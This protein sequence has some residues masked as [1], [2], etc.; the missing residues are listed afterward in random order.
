MPCGA[1]ASLA[2]GCTSTRRHREGD[3]LRDS[4]RRGRVRGLRIRGC[5]R[6]LQSSRRARRGSR[7]AICF[8]ARSSSSVLGAVTTQVDCIDSIGC[9]ENALAIYEQLGLT[10]EAVRCHA[11]LAVV[12]N[13]V[14]PP[15]LGS[16]DVRWISDPARAGDHLRH[17]EALVAKGEDTSK[18]RRALLWYRSEFVREA[19][20]RRRPRCRAARDGDCG[21]LAAKRSLGRGC[22]RACMESHVK[23]PAGGSVGAR[24]RWLGR[25]RTATMMTAAPSWRPPP[26]IAFCF[27]IFT[28]QGSDA[29]GAAQAWQAGHRPVAVSSRNDRAA[30]EQQHC[31]SRRS[32]RRAA[33]FAPRGPAILSREPAGPRRAV[34]GSGGAVR[35]RDRRVAKCRQPPGSVELQLDARNPSACP[36]RGAASFVGCPERPSRTIGEANLM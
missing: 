2:R 34:G 32:D 30:H 6:T 12:R 20:H 21:P 17:A 3:R 18:S 5:D 29:L 4:R 15:R 22:L 13:M 28:L 36:R 25:Q 19:A 35:E 26:D 23:R 14:G 9:F 24:G 8:A 16:R 1:G 11:K 7:A 10:E 27:G 33:A 31:S